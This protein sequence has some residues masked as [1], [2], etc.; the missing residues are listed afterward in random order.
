MWF[1]ATKSTVSVVVEKLINLHCTGFHNALA[2]FLRI[3]QKICIKMLIPT[4]PCGINFWYTNSII[5]ENN[6]ISSQP[7]QQKSYHFF[8]TLQTT[9]IHDASL[10]NDISV[11]L[12]VME[13]DSAYYILSPSSRKSLYYL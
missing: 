6:D 1:L 7:L 10:L 3:S 9:Q 13:N 12:T 4:F 5:V 11:I 8:L 2:T